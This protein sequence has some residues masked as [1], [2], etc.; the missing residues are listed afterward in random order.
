[1]R[2]IASISRVLGTTLFAI[3]LAL[4]LFLIILSDGRVLDLRIGAAAEGP[5]VLAVS[6]LCWAILLAFGVRLTV[7]RWRHHRDLKR[8]VLMVL[9]L[10]PILLAVLS[11]LP[12][13][14]PDWV[15]AVL[16]GLSALAANLVAERVVPHRVTAG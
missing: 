9:L 5:T 15:G 11:L 12:E 6:L 1:M 8:L 14:A 3:V 10:L 7:G 16:V 13:V 4:V 2:S